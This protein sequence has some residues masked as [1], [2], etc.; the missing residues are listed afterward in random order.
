[1][2]LSRRIHSIFVQFGLDPLK[3]LNS[4]RGIPFFFKDLHRYRQLAKGNADAMA[5]SEFFPILSDRFASNGNLDPHYFYQ[6][7]WAARKIYNN[8]PSRHVDI[9]SSVATFVSHL[10]SFRA[11]EIVDVRPL[12]LAIDG[13]TTTVTDATHMTG[14]EDSSLESISTLHAVEHFG[15]GRYGDPVHPTAHLTFMRALA[16]VLK[17]QGR[18]YFSVPCGV[19][20]L[21]FNAHRI[22]AVET[23]LKGFEDLKLVSFS[24][25]TDDHKFHPDC[26]L[27]TVGNERYGCGMFEFSK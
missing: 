17:P 9:G 12:P 19:E 25:V 20:Q 3:A 16:R 18:L 22:F 27:A 4:A 6:D 24:C 11:V 2:S 13:L 7:L 14:Y 23:V 5:V 21:V 15:L 26:D 10:L 1:M 8:N